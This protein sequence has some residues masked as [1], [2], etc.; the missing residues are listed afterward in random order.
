MVT[1]KG[2]KEKR[3]I[4]PS[5]NDEVSHRLVLAANNGNIKIKITR[6]VY[7]LPTEW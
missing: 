5:S 2:G 7:R 1:R 6:P 3:N 4:G